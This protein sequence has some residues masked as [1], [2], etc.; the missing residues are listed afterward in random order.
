MEM[1]NG[2]GAANTE[3]GEAAQA[4]GRER[5]PT[6]APQAP[7]AA[8]RDLIEVHPAAEMFPLMEGPEFDDL[9]ADIRQNNGIKVPLVFWVDPGKKRW[10]LDG[11]NRLNAVEEALGPI[12]MEGDRPVVDAPLGVVKLLFRPE[13]GDPHEIIA[14]LNVHRRHLTREQ[15]QELIDKLLRA[16]PERSDGA[17]A[18]VAKVDPKTVGKRRAGL[19]T[20]G[21]IPY[22]PERTEKSGRKARGRRPSPTPAT[23]KTPASQARDKL[24]SGWAKLLHSKPLDSLQDLD[25]M[26]QDERVQIT[27]IPHA[28]RVALAR[29]YLLALGLSQMDLDPI[30]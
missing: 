29:G 18:K 1:E 22:K 8:W 19:A 15:K 10:L 6:E 14:S 21:E 20:K 11:R 23:P 4:D 12:V 28:H 7:Q 27:A 9:V 13:V 16:N 17:T 25:R 2:S 5:P 24:V 3:A 26:I 30:E